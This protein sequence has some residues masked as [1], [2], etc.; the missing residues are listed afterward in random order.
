MLHCKR[1]N[2]DHLR[3][4]KQAVVL[5]LQTNDRN[6]YVVRQGGQCFFLSNLL[7]FSGSSG[8][9]MRRDM[10]ET[11]MTISF[12]LRVGSSQIVRTLSNMASDFS[13]EL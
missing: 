4:Q 8:L 5:V 10:I 9:R 1:R 7:Q 11:W 3:N 12:V 6:K 2:V 13:K